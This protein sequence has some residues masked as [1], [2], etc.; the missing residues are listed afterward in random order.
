VVVIPSL[1]QI[2]RK[3]WILGKRFTHLFGSALFSAGSAVL[4]WPCCVDEIGTAIGALKCA[5]YHHSAVLD[6]EASQ[7]ED[8]LLL[9][10][11]RATSRAALLSRA[12]GLVKHLTDKALTLLES[13]SGLAVGSQGAWLASLQV[14]RCLGHLCPAIGAIED[15]VFPTL[16]NLRLM[17]SLP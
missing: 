3:F 17:L 5:A 4:L 6:S 9:P 7:V 8:V 12:C 13:A 2:L 15:P 14:G 11:N 16:H 1:A 10:V